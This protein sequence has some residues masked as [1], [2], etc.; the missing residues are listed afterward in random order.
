MLTTEDGTL[1]SSV[2][3]R[4]FVGVS[5]NRQIIREWQLEQVE[6]KWFVFRYIPLKAE[7][8]SAN[9]NEITS[10]FQL[11]LGKNVTIELQQVNEIPLAPTGKVRWII[12]GAHRKRR[13]PDVF[14]E[15]EPTRT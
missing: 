12:N 7:G 2:F 6:A 5:L 15:G 4:H 3:V 13:S 1:L 11:A 9:L 8:L 10:S 14:V